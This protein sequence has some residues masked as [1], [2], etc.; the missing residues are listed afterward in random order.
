MITRSNKVVG[1]GPDLSE[2]EF[3]SI[4]VPKSS[5]TTLDAQLS[6]R[7]IIYERISP[8]FCLAVFWHE[9]QFGRLGI[10]KSFNTKSPGNTRSSITL[11][12]EKVETL[13]GIYIRYPSWQEGF[14][15]L[16]VRLSVPNYIYGRK[17]L[18]TI[19]QIMPVFAPVSDNNSPD[20]YTDA[21]VKMMN[22]WIGEGESMASKPDNIIWVGSPNYY[23][24]RSGQQ[25]VA[26]VDHIMVG[27]MESTRG[28]FNN[29]AS[30]VSSTFGVAKDGRIHQYVALEDAA[31]ANGI[32]EAVDVSIDW[33]VNAVRTR[34]NPNNLTVSIE[35]EGNSGDVMPEAQYQATLAL[36]KWLI[37]L[38]P[39]IKVDRQHI[40]GHYQIM[41]RTKA[42]CPGKGFP[43]SRLINDLSGGTGMT[44]VYDPLMDYFNAHGGEAVFG[45]PVGGQYGTNGSVERNFTL[46]HFILD[47]VTNQV[48]VQMKDRTNPQGFDVGPGIYNKCKELGL[49]LIV[50]EQWFS[51]DPGQPG[52]GKMSRAWAQDAKGVTFVIMASEQPELAKPG[53]DTPWKV[54]VLKV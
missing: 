29:P 40:I 17:G 14:R 16:A 27:T 34:I 12:G 7:A 54:E 13:Q 1:V 10:C 50:G 23:N 46:S 39:A 44:P 32:T 3:I 38:Y 41:S 21:V 2:A 30:Q 51:P 8:A 19:A 6:Y 24:G 15:D 31:W 5:L 18:V 33:L 22:Q 9:S 37:S 49:K 48:L 20:L 4:V 25:V 52:L 53:Q 11:V 42:N 47:K 43:W 36:H 45:K 26:I 28:W 35:H